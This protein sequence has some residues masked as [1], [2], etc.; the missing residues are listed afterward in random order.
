MP[1]TSPLPLP[2]IDAALAA[3]D[4][5][6][7]PPVIEEHIVGIAAALQIVGSVSVWQIE[8]YKPRRPTKHGGDCISRL[9]QREGKVRRHTWHPPRRRLPPRIQVNDSNLLR[10]RHVHVDAATGGIDLKALD[11]KSTRL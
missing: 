2:N 8:H 5:E 6:T 7:T 1:V 4:V 9:I 10:I 11:R 3:A